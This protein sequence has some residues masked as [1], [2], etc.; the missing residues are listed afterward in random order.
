MQPDQP[1]PDRIIPLGELFVGFLLIGLMGFGGIAA[2]ANYVFVERNAWMTQKQF[3]ELF[4]IASILPGGNILNASIMVGDRNQG[5]LGSVVCLF[6]LLLMPLVILLIIATTYDHFSNL[7][8]MKAAMAGG[9]SAVAG[10]II[11]TGMKMGRSLDRTFVAAGFVL[12]TFVA[13]GF[14]RLPLALVILTVVP[15]SIATALFL[16][17]RS[18]KGRGP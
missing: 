4:G 13:I 15:L 6:S 1:V 11:G 18:Q 17:R 8:D 9:A 5:I 2:S 3:V 16:L 10:L 14:F 7:P 12:I